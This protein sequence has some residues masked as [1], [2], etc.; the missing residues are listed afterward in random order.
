[1]AMKLIDQ[2]AKV[3]RR[4]KN[5]G[6]R[7][8]LAVHGLDIGAVGGNELGRLLAK[9]LNRIDRTVPGFEDFATD[10]VRGIQRGSPARSLFYHALASPAVQVRPDGRPL[11]AFPT[12]AE[13]ELV[14]NYVFAA[15]RASL[16]ELQ[17]EHCPQG[18]LSV[19]VFATEYR[20]A[21]QTCHGR[22]ADMVYAR[23]GV[24]RVGTAEA[25]YHGD[26]R[27]FL[28]QSESS[29]F[30]V[31]VLPARYAACL[32]V[33]RRGNARNFLPMRFRSSRDIATDP[34]VRE[35]A[36]KPDDQR[37]FWV[38]VHKLFAGSEC[39][40]DV[41]DLTLEFSSRHFNDK[42][43]RVHELIGDTLPPREYPY[44]FSEGIAEF[45]DDPDHGTGLLMP[46][47]HERLV[48][49]AR[50]RQG[51]WATYAV[52]TGRIKEEYSS[53][54]ANEESAGRTGVRRGPQYVNAKIQVDPDGKLV[55]LN[56]D[57]RYATLKE[58]ADAGDYRAL[59][60]VDFTGD[61]WVA[62]H[63]PELA[64]RPEI[65]GGARAAYSLVTAPD[66]FPI[67]DQRELTVWTHSRQVPKKWRKLIW[68]QKT[69]ETLSDT[70]RPAN[71]QLPVSKGDNPFD[72]NEDGMTALVPLADRR[73]PRG[74]SPPQ[75]VA[76]RHSHLPD[77]AAGIF[78]P[79]WDVSVDK[80]GDV[81][82]GLPH[83][84]AYG[85]GSPFPEDVKLCA[86]LSNFW[87]SASPDTTR[88]MEPV[89]EPR[90][91]HTVCPLTD[92]EIGQLGDLPW[93]GVPGPRVVVWQGKELAEFPY[94]HRVDYV[95]NALLNQFSLRR[96]AQ[97]DPEEYEDRVFAM[98]LV[99][100]TI[101][102][103]PKDWNDWIVLSFRR[104]P[105][106]PPGTD[107]R[108][109]FPA[110][111]DLA[112]LKSATT[113]AKIAFHAPIFR[114][115]M[116][117]RLRGKRAEIARIAPYDIRKCLLPLTDR[118]IFFA[119]PKQRLVV[120]RAAGAARWMAKKLAP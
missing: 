49:P 18:R 26:A 1:M 40:R 34:Q 51:G 3:W 84:A 110:P 7:D 5:H 33:L 67:V 95:Q 23:T 101:S 106:D 27:G 98:F 85:L 74:L 113:A 9:R 6:W 107:D 103:S 73:P 78:D 56:S 53:F 48:E 117:A 81:E 37:D 60:F 83:L 19:I 88:L 104:V 22:H 20:P 82:T 25:A 39:L 105:L 75:N 35:S 79:G 102:R 119:F 64:V 120:W 11:T 100:R 77:D 12:L 62:V 92:A 86:A 96:T 111:D 58:R 32:A 112:E 46:E 21:S 44:Q 69:P 115:E 13:I 114:F 16:A 118:R 70:R 36:H 108:R 17:K 57:T 8:L 116:F 71:L 2:I 94:M 24:A 90:N 72:P 28:P 55:N 10:G 29:P 52:T 65:A 109:E 43:Y 91:L 89:P 97:I 54:T 59:H 41:P 76:R 87:P 30:A 14:E 61:G 99:H 31:R 50:T 80:L 42:I 15:A 4:L 47:P 38:P 93:D 45:S 63:C 68:G 66:F